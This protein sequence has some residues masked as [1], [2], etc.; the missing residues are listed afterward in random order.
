MKA[1]WLKSHVT[2]LGSIQKEPPKFW[3]NVIVKEQVVAPSMRPGSCGIFKERTEHACSTPTRHKIPTSTGKS[4][5]E[6][7]W[8]RGIERTGTLSFT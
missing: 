6:P 7:F 2:V 1:V 4:L 3:P 8:V 5:E